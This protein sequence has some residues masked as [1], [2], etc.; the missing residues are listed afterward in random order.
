M[1]FQDEKPKK[2]KTKIGEKDKNGTEKRNQK[3]QDS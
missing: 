3:H 1:T 2:A